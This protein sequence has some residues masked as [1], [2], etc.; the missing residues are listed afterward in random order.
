MNDLPQSGVVSVAPQ[1]S[2][3]PVVAPPDPVVGTPSGA[4]EMEF[5][6]IASP[7]VPLRDVSAQEIELP[8]EVSQAGVS[9]TPTTIPIP[10]NVQQMGV[11]PAGV[12]VQA[13]ATP[14]V[15]PLTDVQ[16]VEG[17]K[18]GVKTSWRWLAE[19]C[20]R[21]IKQ[22]HH[23]AMKQPSNNTTTQQNNNSTH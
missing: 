18:Q 21:R 11:A 4:K 2:D 22:L 16:I 9:I 20:V 14:Q 12:N 6:R 10:A 5:G 15:V 7:E 13:V 8:K 3:A 23:A 19:W 17:L 1:P